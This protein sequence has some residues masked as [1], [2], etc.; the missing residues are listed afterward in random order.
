M[1][2]YIRGRF[3]R[4]LKKRKGDHALLAKVRSVLAAADAARGVD[5][6]PEF[7]WLQGHPGF[8]RIRV[9]RFRLGVF[10][11]GA[12]IDFVRCLPRGK[13]YDVFP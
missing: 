1:N 10:L 9:G 4:D 8:G 7:A 3:T 11:D 6:L 12:D 2:V 5:D 13:I